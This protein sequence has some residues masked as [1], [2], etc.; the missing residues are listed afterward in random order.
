M[1]SGFPREDAFDA[2]YLYFYEELLTPER[3]RAEVELVWK[4]LE[5]EPGLELLDLA[6]GHGRIANP[7]AERGLLVTGLDA[8]PLFLDLAREDAAERGVGV[9]YVEGDMRS[10]PWVDR[11]DRVLCWFTSFGYFSD[12]ENRGVLGGVF[13]AL[14]SGGMFLLE[15]N[16]RDNLLGRYA[17]EVVVERGEDRMTDRHRLD[18]QTGRSHDQRTIVREGTSRTF[19]FSVRMFSA[20]ELRDWLRAAGFRDTYAYGED[21]EPLTL[22]HRRMAVVGRK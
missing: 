8:T 3:T 13:R 5:L 14:K 1:G 6:C 20:A 2:D 7:L 15:M 17:D 16:H 18:L 19:D 10:I 22:E 11:F 4:L 21:G 9:E 12:E